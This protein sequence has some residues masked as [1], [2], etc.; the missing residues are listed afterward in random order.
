[1]TRCRFG[2]RLN[3]KRLSRL[4]L[5]MV[6][7]LLITLWL[8]HPVYLAC[9]SLPRTGDADWHRM[10]RVYGYA[11]LWLVAAAAIACVDSS[12][13][14]KMGLLRAIH[15]PLLLL[16]SVALT[17]VTVEML[18]LLTR[19]VRPN[20]SDGVFAWR[21]WLDHPLHNGGLSTPSS[22]AAVAFAGTWMLCRFFP[23]ASPVWLALALGCAMT[24]VLNEAHYVSDVW[25]AALVSYMVADMLYRQ[26]MR[27][28]R[29]HA[30]AVRRLSRS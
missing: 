12:Q 24:R 21:P 16:M 22:H 27:N 2:R 13:I 30:I 23:R 18:K 14:S 6:V 3:R 20:L 15:R 25:L 5:V 29:R 11:P 10:L 26:H 8:D 28:E 19:R 1:M 17:G 7:G 4:L 9:L